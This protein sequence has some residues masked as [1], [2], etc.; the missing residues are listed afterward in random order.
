M[1]GRSNAAMIGNYCIDAN[2]L[3]MA[4]VSSDLIA[5][6]DFTLEKKVEQINWCNCVSKVEAAIVN[7][8]IIGLEDDY[9][10]LHATSY[11]IRLCLHSINA[12]SVL[13]KHRAMHLDLSMFL[14]AS[15]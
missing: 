12:L 13:W 11:F 3:L 1:I 2:L 5:P 14:C 10:V 9:G 4:Q 15:I 7:R 8:D 6:K